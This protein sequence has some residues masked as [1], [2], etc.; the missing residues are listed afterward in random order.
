MLTLAHANASAR[1][2][3]S[4]ISAHTATPTTHAVRKQP[5]RN[6]ASASQPG[7]S[8]WNPNAHQ[9]SAASSTN[10]ARL[11]TIP[12]IQ[13][14]SV[15]WRMPIGARN[16]CLS[17][18][19]QTS[20][21]TAYATSS[22]QTLT[23]ESAI[24]PTSTNDACA[25][26]S[27]RNRD[28]RPMERTPTIGQ[29]SSS[30]KKNTLRAPMRAFRSV[31]AQ[32]ARSSFRQL[33]EDL[34]QLR[35]AHLNVADDDAVGVERAQQLR[36]SL[37]GLVHRALD[38][39]VELDA[40]KNARD[41]GEPWHPRRIQPKRDDLPQPDLALELSGRSPGEDPTALDERDLVAELVRLAHVM[42]RQHDGDALL[43]A[44]PSDVRADPHRDVGV[45]AER[46]LVEE[47]EL[48]IVHE[49]LGEGHPLLQPGRQIAVR[50]PAVRAEL[51]QLDQP[52]DAPAKRRAAQPVQPPV[53]REDLGD[54]QAPE[55]GRPA[56]RH[57]EPAPQR[58]GLTDD[59][60]AQHHDGAAVGCQQRGE[61]REQRRL[62]RSVGAED[63]DDR[64]ALHRQRD[65]A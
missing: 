64:A 31:T 17:D 63:P 21:R 52:V 10:T 2:P 44:E 13:D 32:T 36:E 37:L 53:E 58:A 14:P 15:R 5:R 19:D 54:A 33:N 20:S 62:A 42:G 48:G 26:V 45:E 16:W 43:A 38:P 35:L 24:V 34:L 4:V 40:A 22:W 1:L 59:V 18:F 55:K 3:N 8:T 7:W 56:A 50:D 47:E 28:I 49:R 57:V 11:R 12:T 39:P 51:A 29:K 9:P 46:R 6:V 61:D 30:K 27:S 25:S 23:T 60:V 65:T 41:L